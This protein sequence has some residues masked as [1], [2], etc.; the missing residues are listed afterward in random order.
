MTADQKMAR[1][2]SVGT[3]ASSH[4]LTWLIAALVVGYAG[5]SLWAHVMSPMRSAVSAQCSAN[6][7]MHGRNPMV[8]CNWKALDATIEPGSNVAFGDAL[9]WQ[10]FPIQP[11]GRIP[12]G[13]TFTCTLALRA[14]RLLTI[15]WFFDRAAHAE[16]IYN[17]RRLS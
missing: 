6:G 5:W 1:P 7:F 17:C 15:W 11:D 14:E 16:H 4:W 13:A 3:G 9:Q 12:A 8:A 10:R 2:G